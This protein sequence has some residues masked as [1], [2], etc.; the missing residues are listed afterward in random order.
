MK[1]VFTYTGIAIILFVFGCKKDT[2]I[3]GKDALVF[4]SADT[5]RFDT[6]FTSVGSVTQLFKI[7]NG[8]NQKL[9]ID[10]VTLKGGA[11]S[12]FKINVDGATGPGVSVGGSVPLWMAL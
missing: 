5:V 2:F 6:V 10:N 3:T 11:G 7:T 4:L 1:K 8:N 9:K 12:A